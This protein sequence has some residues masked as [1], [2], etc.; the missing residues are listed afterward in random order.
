MG[1]GALQYRFSAGDLLVYDRQETTVGLEEPGDPVVVRQQIQVWC[2]ARGAD[3]EC[4][5]LVELCD[6]SG[7]RPQPSRGLVFF[8]DEVGGRRLPPESAIRVPSVAA[9]LDVL[10]ILPRTIQSGS[11]WVS[12]A[13]LSGRR[14]RNVIRGSDG[15]GSGVRVDFASEDAPG[16]AGV[17]ERLRTGSFWF[18]SSTGRVARVESEEV[19]RRAGT[20]IRSESTLR[21]VLAHSPRW[22]AR[23]EAESELYRDTQRHEDRLLHEVVN[24]PEGWTHWL[25]QLDR[26]W[27]AL[28][29]DV[30]VRGG[31]PFARL[32]LDRRQ[33][34]RAEMPA[35]QGA[36]WAWEALD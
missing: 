36:G 19:D 3:E 33:I 2:L 18:D 6:I 16:V 15:R 8:V 34:L 11:T 25:E 27:S 24:H 5:L 1:Q 4:L 14:E 30:D 13:D 35:L 22:A 12:P 26:V 7:A 10:P 32:A 21:Q 23:R 17:L 29:S 28:R 31:S 20:R 9:A